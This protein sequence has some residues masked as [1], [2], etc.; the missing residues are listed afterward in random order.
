MN[1]LRGQK[2]DITRN[3]AITDISAVLEWQTT[4]KEIEIDGAAFLLDE[5]G[6]C[7]NDES[8]VFYGQPASIEGSVKHFESTNGQNEIQL[9][10]DKIPP[11]IKKIA[12]TLTIHNGEIKDRASMWFLLLV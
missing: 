11:T 1:I 8:F 3:T 10:L 5:S 6:H 9:S 12:L 7:Q 4:N 2:V